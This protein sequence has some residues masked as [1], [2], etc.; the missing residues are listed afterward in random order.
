MSAQIDG[1]GTPGLQR[2]SPPDYNAAYTFMCWVRVNNLDIAHI[3]LRLEL[4]QSDYDQA[5]VS[6]STSAFHCNGFMADVDQHQGDTALSVSPDTWYA[7]ALVRTGPTQLLQYA[8]TD[9]ASFALSGTHSGASVAGRAAALSVLLGRTATGG[10]GI[11]LDGH[12]V[13]AKLFTTALSLS[14]IRKELGYWNFASRL[15]PWANW[16]LLHSKTDDTS[17]NGRTLTELGTVAMSHRNPNLGASGPLV[18]QGALP[19]RP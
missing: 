7:Y 3:V 4:S 12:I 19:F 8:G 17:G 15:S 14:D 2:D 13:G 1:T 16:P 5:Y 18:A 9:L 11:G 6:A 10:D